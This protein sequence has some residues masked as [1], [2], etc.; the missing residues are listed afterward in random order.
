MQIVELIEKLQTIHNKYGNVHVFTRD[1][2]YDQPVE[3][4]TVEQEMLDVG[5]EMT[6]KQALERAMKMP[7]CQEC[8]SNVNVVYDAGKTIRSVGGEYVNVKMCAVIC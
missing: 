8:M 2:M 7:N 1:E 3:V 4:Q 5:V 6:R